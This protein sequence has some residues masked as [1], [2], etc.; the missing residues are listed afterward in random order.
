MELLFAAGSANRGVLDQCRR[1][2]FLDHF[3][4]R[5]IRD[6]GKGGGDHMAKADKTSKAPAPAKGGKTSK[7]SKPPKSRTKLLGWVMFVTFAVFSPASM[8]LFGVGMIPSIIASAMDRKPGKTALQTVASVN[9]CGVMPFASD[10][11]N[12]GNTIDYVKTILQNHTDW[13]IMYGAALLGVLVY[14]VVPIIIAGLL[15]FKS[16]SELSE[17]TKQMD[18]LRE[19]WGNEV[20][21]ESFTDRMLPIITTGG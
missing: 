10:L 8:M 20:A 19:E 6:L 1:G 13:A 3:V 5:Q 18:A 7:A 2:I 17:L 21:E 16:S 14:I 4:L 12:N 11:W 9:F 15:D